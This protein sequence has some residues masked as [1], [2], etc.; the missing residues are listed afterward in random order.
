MGIKNLKFEETKYP[1]VLSVVN[2]LAEA[3]KRKPHDSA[4]RL[5]VE[6][7]TAKLRH[8]KLYSDFIAAVRQQG[9]RPTTQPAKAAG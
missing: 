7:G 9:N 3:E 1:E 8:P 5:L 2:R 6:V 4:K